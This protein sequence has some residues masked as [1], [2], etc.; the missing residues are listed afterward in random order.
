MVFLNYQLL[1]RINIDSIHP[2]FAWFAWDFQSLGNLR[3]FKFDASKMR[4]EISAPFRHAVKAVC[5]MTSGNVTSLLSSLPS[6][7][8]FNDLRDAGRRHARAE[9]VAPQNIHS[10]AHKSSEKR[11]MGCKP[12][13]L[14]AGD[15]TQQLDKKTIKTSVYNATRAT[16]CALGVDSTGLT[17]NHSNI[18]YTKPHVLCQRLELMQLT[19]TSK[20]WFH[21]EFLNKL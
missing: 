11:C 12:M 7:L 3:H 6:E 5:G 16:D 21:L 4:D 13:A 1:S 17:R 2:T 14:E 9:K 20:V 19:L 15:W 8:A 10:V 18:W